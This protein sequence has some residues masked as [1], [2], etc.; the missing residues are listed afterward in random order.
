[1]GLLDRYLLRGIAPGA[2]LGAGVILFALLLNELVRHIQLFLTQ[3]ANPVTVGLALLQLVPGVS[4]VV[5]PSAL[6]LGILL[7]LNGL[8]AGRELI[9]MR[10][11]G[12]SPWR[13]L[14]PIGAASALA[15]GLCVWLMLDVV[16]HANQRFLDLSAQLLSARLRTEIEPDIFYDELLE[17]RVLLVRETPPGEDGWR[18]VFLAEVGSAREPTIFL[19]ERGRLVA[20]AVEREAFLVLEQVEVHDAVLEHPG[21]YGI[22]RVA[23]IRLP[24]S[25]DTI[26]GPEK[27]SPYQSTRAMPLPELVAAWEETQHP[28]YRV[29]IHKKFALPAACLA[30][31]LIGLGLGLRPSPQPARAGAFALAALVIVGYSIPLSSGEEMAISGTVAPW[32]GAWGANALTFAAGAAALLLASRELDPLAPVARL[33]ARLGRAAASLGAALGRR[34]RTRGR[35]RL[36][37]FG[38]L[39]DR[40]LVSGLVRFT[41]LVLVGLLSVWT[42][43]RL[44]TLIG[45][46]VDNGMAGAPLVRY[47]WLSLPGFTTEV[48]PLAALAGTLIAFGFLARHGEVT[49]FVAGGVSLARMTLPA[50]FLGLLVGAAGHGVQEVLLPVTGPGAEDLETRIRGEGRR[51]LD[52][53]ERHWREGPD[54]RIIHYETFDPANA[55]LVGLSVF[56]PDAASGR[57][58]GRAFAGSAHWSDAEGAWIGVGGW[59]RRPLSETGARAFSMSEIPGV[60]PPEAFLGVDLSPRHLAFRDLEERITAVAAA[61][62][63]TTAL[64]AEREN[65]RARPFAALVM[66][67]IALPFAFR[68]ANRSG[69]A[70]AAIAI[71]IGILFLV[72]TRFFGFLG[73]AELLRPELAAWS[74][75]LLFA[76]AAVFL[77]LRSTDAP[78]RSRV[79][80]RRG[81][82]SPDRAEIRAR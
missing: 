23:E 38:P 15:C 12:I 51:T 24:L 55:V 10:A 49:A 4:A 32:L 65:R 5:I 70:S 48:L 42:S 1:M 80:P 59:R 62:H 40:Y 16:P 81:S 69:L 20:N 11:G 43:G 64:A 79:R 71:G 76:L 31:G 28:A 46:A 52:P 18:E 25:A 68:R 9:A 3:G 57:L 66:V 82:A 56:E 14:W 72:A 39:L 45:E 78:R 29:E 60:P 77:L 75:N 2:V 36:A 58:A 22:Q 67:L 41:A 13:L 7:A 19:A 27:V 73:E 26:F 50:L 17:D 74:P 21:R 35:R 47:L 34:R 30:F 37:G 33:G 44:V 63:D 8:S 6:L 54:G 61:G 53:L